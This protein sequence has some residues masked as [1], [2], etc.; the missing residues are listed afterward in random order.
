[1][2]GRRKANYDLPPRM[3]LKC[4]SYYYVTRD[5]QWL[6]LGKDLPIAKRK[7]AELSGLAPTGGMTTLMDR[8]MQEIAPK[9]A[10][11]TYKDNLSEIENLRKV[12]GEMEVRA[13][14]PMH[15]AKYLDLRGVDAPVRAN[16]E[17]AL[18]S[19]IF[20]MGMRWGMCDTNPCRGVHRNTEAKRDRYIT[21][22]EFRAVWSK[23][24]PMVQCVMDLAY[25]TAQRIGDL[26]ALRRGDIT[27]TGVYF[28]QGKTGKKLIVEMTPELREVL[29]R[30]ASIHRIKSMFVIATKTGSK[31]TYDGI[32]AM[33]RRYVTEAKIDDF[34]FHDIRAKALTDAKRAGIDAQRLAGHATETMTAHYVKLREVEMVVGLSKISA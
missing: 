25:M 2:V 26:L 16:R 13:V 14:K 8:Y 19:H 1:M 33:F 3:Y 20:T 18:L 12:F 15:I 11:R 31:Y 10:P 7:W 32:S 23:A 27:D 4:G 30:A 28:K 24:T 22:E 9:K 17:K 21:D 34:H 5:N 6:N 29:D